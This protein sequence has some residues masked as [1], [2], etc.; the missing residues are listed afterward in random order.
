MIQNADDAR[1]TEIKLYLDCRVLQTLSPELLPKSSQMLVQKFEGPALL[2]YNNAA[3]KKDD[4]ESIQSLQNSRKAKNPYQ[5][6]KFGVGF[7]SVYHITG[8]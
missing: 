5:V 4:W 1:A 6:G 3:F 8:G 7:N 2:S